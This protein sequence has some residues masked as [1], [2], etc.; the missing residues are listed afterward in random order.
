MSALFYLPCTCSGYR[1]FY[2]VCFFAAFASVLQWHV[3]TCWLK[4]LYPIFSVQTA[5]ERLTYN[6]YRTCWAEYIKSLSFSVLWTTSLGWCVVS[7]CWP[8][9]VINRNTP[10]LVMCWKGYR[11]VY[12]GKAASACIIM[13]NCWEGKGRIYCFSVYFSKR[14][15]T[16]L[17]AGVQRAKYSNIF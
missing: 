16:F 9:T 8:T 6:G 13:E 14:W 17:Y 3:T 7:G 11:K 2:I 4:K 12:G 1:H 15:E 10:S 5:V